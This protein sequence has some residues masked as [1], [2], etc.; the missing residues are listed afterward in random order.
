VVRAD[1]Q[2]RRAAD[3]PAPVVDKAVRAAEAARAVKA[4]PVDN[5]VL[6]EDRA[7]V[8]KAAVSQARAAAEVLADNPVH[9]AALAA[10]NPALAAVA[11]PAVVNQVP[12]AAAVLEAA[13]QAQA[14]VVAPVA[15]AAQVVRAAP[16]AAS[17]GFQTKTN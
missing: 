2:A 11:V 1:S 8:H 16:A 13:A 3:N 4:A 15:E 17:K 14:E 9:R 10:V 6:K 5:L 7:V 12:A